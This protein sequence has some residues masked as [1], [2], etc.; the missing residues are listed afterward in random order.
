M[1]EMERKRKRSKCDQLSSVRKQNKFHCIGTIF[2][3]PLDYLIQQHFVRLS[4][5]MECLL[6]KKYPK[7]STLI[8]FAST[9]SEIDS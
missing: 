2:I 4:T 9:H 1:K 6:Q 3:C 7:K 5:F 8:L